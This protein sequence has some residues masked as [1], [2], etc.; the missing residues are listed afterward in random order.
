MIMNKQKTQNVNKIYVV[1]VF[2]FHNSI[3]FISMAACVNS[4]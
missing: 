1:S 2:N 4:S 3:K